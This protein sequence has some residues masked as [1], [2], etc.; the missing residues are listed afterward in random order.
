MLLPVL[1]QLSVLYIVSKKVVLG[2]ATVVVLVLVLS[3]VIVPV[4]VGVS[5]M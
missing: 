4:L 1:V 5:G 2:L 3:L